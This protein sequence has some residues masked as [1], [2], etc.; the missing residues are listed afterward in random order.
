MQVSTM[1]NSDRK[2]KLMFFYENHI[3][4]IFKIRKGEKY[5]IM[6]IWPNE[7]T[8]K[9][10]TWSQT[11]VSFIKRSTVIIKSGVQLITIRRLSS[12]CDGTFK[13]LFL[14]FVISNPTRD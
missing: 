13:I 9:P 7:R 10:T 2:Y 1:K 12:V 11:N 3:L 4:V 6:S 5:F 8:L 14:K